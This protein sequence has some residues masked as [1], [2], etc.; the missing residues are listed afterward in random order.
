VQLA[1]VP[2]EPQ[3]VAE[4]LLVHVVPEQ[5]YPPVQVPSVATVLHR[6]VQA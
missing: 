2:E 6:L 3:A 1:Q 5:Q 4:W